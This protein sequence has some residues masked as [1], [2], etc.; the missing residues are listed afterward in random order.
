M[1]L[2]EIFAGGKNIWPLANG[3]NS[4]LQYIF[5][6]GVGFFDCLFEKIR[7]FCFWTFKNT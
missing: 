4:I 6:L 7:L 5:L 1:K 2:K 3:F